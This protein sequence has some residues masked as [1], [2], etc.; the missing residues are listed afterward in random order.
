MVDLLTQL[1]FS[2]GSQGLNDTLMWGCA[3]GAALGGPWLHAVGL[4]FTACATASLEV[5]GGWVGSGARC[6]DRERP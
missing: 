3:P 4:Q 1:G 6:L 2:V 5:E